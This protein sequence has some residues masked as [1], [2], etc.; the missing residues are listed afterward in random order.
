MFNEMQ[1]YQNLLNIHREPPLFSASVGLLLRD[2][3]HHAFDRLEFSFYRKVSIMALQS[4][5]QRLQS[6]EADMIGQNNV[7]YVHFFILNFP[8][9]A[10][11]HGKTIESARFRGSPGFQPNP[12][13]LSW[14]YSQCAKAHIRGFSAGMS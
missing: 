8:D 11:L 14:Q 9:A 6:V 3:L 10:A 4:G 5:C 12:L 13:L 2:D 1:V 7:F